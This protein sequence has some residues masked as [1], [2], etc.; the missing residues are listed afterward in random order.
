MTKCGRS[1]TM[2]GNAQQ[3]GGERLSTKIHTVS[4][5]EYK[6]IKNCRLH[7]NQAQESGLVYLD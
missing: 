5:S 4:V 2:F 1:Q 6:R 3:S 7:L